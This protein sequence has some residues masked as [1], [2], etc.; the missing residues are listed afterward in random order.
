MT[1]KRKNKS[2]S[3]IHQIH[4]TKQFSTKNSTPTQTHRFLPLLLP[5]NR[6]ICQLKPFWKSRKKHRLPKKK[7]WN[8]RVGRISEFESQIHVTQTVNSLQTKINN[9][10][11]YSRPPCLVI[12]GLEEPGDEDEIQKI[13]V[14]IEEET[15]I[16]QNTVIKNLKKTGPIGQVD[17]AG[18]QKKIAKFT[19]DSF[20][21]TVYTKQKKLTADQK[22]KNQQIR[23]RIKFDPS[24]TRWRVKLLELANKNVP[25]S[26]SSKVCLHGHATI[27]RSPVQRKHVLGIQ[28]ENNIANILS[29]LDCEYELF[30]EIYHSDGTWFDHSICHDTPSSYTQHSIMRGIRYM[31]R[32]VQGPVGLT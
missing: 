32:L 26:W 23:V 30:D 17:N 1:S 31:R 12:N 13:G 24:L 10:E 21:K 20:R 14:T 22:R 3:Q 16:S 27:L 5:A 7:S 19:A 29:R 9:Q 8:F 4:K 2:K 18:K 25:E 15:G 11:Q 6:T 28:S